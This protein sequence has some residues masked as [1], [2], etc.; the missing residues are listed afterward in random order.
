MNQIQ[1]P[2]NKR[3]RR[4]NC[5]I[6][7]RCQPCRVYVYILVFFLRCFHCAAGHQ[8]VAL[9]CAGVLVDDSFRQLVIFSGLHAVD[10]AILVTFSP[11]ANR[12]ATSHAFSQHEL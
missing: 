3:K 11:F 9:A 8:W 2:Q 1:L 5:D 12:S 7:Q 6:L 10:L 4:V